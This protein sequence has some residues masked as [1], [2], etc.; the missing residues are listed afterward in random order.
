MSLPSLDTRRTAI[1]GLLN[2]R[3]PA[4]ALA[5]YYAFHHAPDRTELFVHWDQTSG[6]AD[7][8]LIRART[9]MDLFRPL[10]TFRAA[11][12][13]AA[14]EL[15]KVGLLP[16]R[17]VY[18]S[19]PHERAPWANQHLN[20][21]EASLNLIYRLDVNRFRSEINILVVTSTGADGSPR[22][23]IRNGD[24]SALAGVNWQSPTFAEVFVQTDAAVRGKG[25]GKSVLTAVVTSLLKA[26]RTPLHIVAE[27]NTAS[28]N[29]AESIGFVDTGLR[30]FTGQAVLA[31]AS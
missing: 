14:V 31:T 17:P 4:D 25:W 11:S 29:L 26:G 5:S 23:E 21:T 28:I 10:V 30:E 27:S 24:F 6:Q 3:S 19:I 18:L 13:A 9:G 15:F 8:C 2:E 16:N 22:C 1:R 7:G 12:E 20:I